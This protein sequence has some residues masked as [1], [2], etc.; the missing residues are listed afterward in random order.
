MS[1]SASAQPR[2][3]SLGV[4]F[5]T[6]YI[7]LIGFSIIFPLV[8]DILQHYL[9]VEGSTGV[10]GG[11]V[12]F[13]EHIAQMLGKDRNF[14]AVLLG[15]ALSSIYALLQFVFAPY[16]GAKSDQRGRRHVLLMTVAG[17]AAS[18]AL[19]VFSGSFWLFVAARFLGGVFGGNI[20]VAT[21]AVADVTSRQERAKAMGL[22][23]AAFGLGL[24][25]G[26][27]IGAIT[28]Q[29]NLLD[30]HPQWAA[31]GL[32]PF[33]VPA[34][35]SLGLAVINFIWVR[36]R[37]DETLQDEN[38]TGRPAKLELK[39]PLRAIRDLPSP[40]VQRINCIGFTFA[41]AFCAMEFSLTFLG[42]DRFGFTAKQNGIMLGYLGV[43]SI[44][45][46]GMIV[47]K[48]LKRQSETRV[49]K[50]G[51]IL[52]TVGFMFVG[53]SPNVTVLY[54][55]LGILALG[56]GF[57]N[58]ATS[59]LISLYSADDEQGRALG[60]FRSLGSL[61]RA[62][63]PVLAGVVFWVVSGTAVFGAA[64]AL[65]LGSWSLARTLPP[66]QP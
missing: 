37:F 14:A 8:P 9:G 28:A 11:L 17:T 15:G 53:I 32:H 44:I 12:N 31:W 10:L 61:A 4:I 59:G 26:P 19:W 45:T 48:L 25:T 27:A 43:C 56:A 5:L 1:S 29:W 63:T 47:R 30:A 40:A 51:L 65:A 58:P 20:S 3:L 66:P 42:A 16:W 38:R 46:Q 39:H 18:Y 57:V 21:A 36:A 50:T 22:V 13:T 64:A 24:V 60:I 7:D 33:S 35:F 55:G 23:G 34:L 2:P 6:L 62:I 52:A 54:I 41:L 49:L